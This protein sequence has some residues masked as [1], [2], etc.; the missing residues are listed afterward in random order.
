MTLNNSGATAVCPLND[1]GTCRKV[2]LDA[3]GGWNGVCAC[4]KKEADGV[5]CIYGATHKPYAR[6][7]WEKPKEPP[8]EFPWN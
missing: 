4:G 2:A 8:K 5:R 3:N 1:F 7:P 6:M